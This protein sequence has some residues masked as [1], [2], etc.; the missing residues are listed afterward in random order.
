MRYV[1]SGSLRFNYIGPD[2]CVVYKIKSSDTLLLESRAANI[3]ESLSTK[4]STVDQ[5]EA[6]G[7]KGIESDPESL[8]LDEGLNHLVAAGLIKVVA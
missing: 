1:L 7:I 8:R 6:C 4:P 2:E 3:L 5:L